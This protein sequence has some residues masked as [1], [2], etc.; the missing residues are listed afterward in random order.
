[1]EKL[2]LRDL[3]AGLRPALKAA[4]D[5]GPALVSY[6]GHG[7]TAVWA[8]ENV[9]NNQDLASSPGRPSSRCS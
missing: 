7:A 2:Y 6:V 5:S 4:L 9:W 1:M 3:G 8:S